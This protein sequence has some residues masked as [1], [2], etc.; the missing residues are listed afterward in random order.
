MDFSAT[1][2][3]FTTLGTRVRAGFT[4]GQKIGTLVQCAQETGKGSE[5]QLWQGY[6]DSSLMRIQANDNYS[7]ILL[8]K[9]YVHSENVSFP[10]VTRLQEI[11]HNRR[12]R[13]SNETATS[14]CPKRT[15]TRSRWHPPPT[16]NGRIR[17]ELD[18]Q[19]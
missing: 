7:N 2:A 15:H 11:R 4:R 9:T 18:A 1:Q 6:R 14:N 8:I 19:R 12:S 16:S 13:Q 3:N 10:A 5:V 17:M